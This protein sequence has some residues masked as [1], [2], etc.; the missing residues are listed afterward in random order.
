MKEVAEQ[1]KIQEPHDPKIRISEEGI[2]EIQDDDKVVASLRF[3]ENDDFIYTNEFKD[4][5]IKMRM[6]QL[7][8]RLKINLIG[9]NESKQAEIQ[10]QTLEKL[11]IDNINVTPQEAREL[12]LKSDMMIIPRMELSKVSILDQIRAHYDPM[13][14][15][16]FDSEEGVSR[17]GYNPTTQTL[18][19]WT[20]QKS[21]RKPQLL[22]VVQEMRGSTMVRMMKDTTPIEATTITMYS[23]MFTKDVVENMEKKITKYEKRLKLSNDE[24]N[25]LFIENVNLKQQLQEATTVAG[26]EVVVY[27]PP[28]RAEDP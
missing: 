9:A 5:W 20:K 3:M 14:V 7:D 11:N 17:T 23:A 26:D 19:L 1:Q 28:I 12:V 27:H 25:K 16:Q 24:V 2:D 4:F 21:T 15:A 6:E 22:D 8:E 10:T 13:L 18:A